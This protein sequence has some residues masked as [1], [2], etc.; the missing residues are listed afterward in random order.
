MCPTST[1]VSIYDLVWT[2]LAGPEVSVAERRD[3]EVMDLTHQAIPSM[4]RGCTSDE[5]IPGLAA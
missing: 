1:T 3:Q 5:L 4:F 2:E